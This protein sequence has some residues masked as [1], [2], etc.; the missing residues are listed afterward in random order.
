MENSKKNVWKPIAI[1]SICLLLIVSTCYGLGI[2]YKQN[3]IN[4]AENTE[5]QEVDFAKALSLWNDDAAA[6][7]ELAEYL[8]AVTEEGSADF[9]PVEN[10]IAVFD[11][12]GTL[13]CETDPCYFDH[14]VYYYRV[15]HSCFSDAFY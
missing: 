5:T 8:K 11:L 12:D 3:D 14:C 2:G 6:K 10:R 15:I 7:K 9:I 4:K 1:I 13:A